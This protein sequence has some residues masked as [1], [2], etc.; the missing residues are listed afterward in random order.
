MYKINLTSEVRAVFS[1]HSYD[2]T[3]TVLAATSLQVQG[4]RGYSA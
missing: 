4:V 2:T 3:N 1:Y